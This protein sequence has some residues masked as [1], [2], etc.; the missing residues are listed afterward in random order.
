MICSH[1][2]YVWGVYPVSMTCSDCKLLVLESPWSF[3]IPTSLP[4]GFPRQK[5]LNQGPNPLLEFLHV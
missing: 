3:G 2:I 1:G 5:A 4:W